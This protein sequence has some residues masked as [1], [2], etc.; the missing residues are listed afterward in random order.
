MRRRAAVSLCCALALP[1]RA[2]AQNDAT[3]EKRTPTSSEGQG[4]I[5]GCAGQPISD[6]VVITQP[7]FTERLPRRIEWVRTTVRR[8]HVNTDDEV[9]RR[10]LLLKVGEPCNQISRAESERILRAQP[11]LVEARIRV[12]D[13]ESGGVRL[14]VETRDDFSAIFS[15]VLSRASPVFRGLRFGESN[16]LGSASL[17]ALEWRDGEQLNDVLGAEFTDHQFAGERIELRAVAR[18]NFYGQEMRA[19]LVHPY[20][21]DLQRFAWVGSAG[22]TRDLVQL[23]RPDREIN[24]V[25][26]RREFANVG[27]IA[28]V[29]SVGR[30]K[31]LGVSLSRERERAD[32]MPVLI[33]PQGII[34]D[35]LSAPLSGFRR[36]RVVRVNA[37][38]GLRAVRFVRV[39][40]FDALTGEQDVRSGL[41]LG[42][43][44]GQSLPISQS[45]DRDRFLASNLYLGYGG[46]RSFAGFEAIA[47]ARQDRTTGIWD[48]VI[49][50]GRLAWYLR[51]A[52]KQ[53][54][55]LQ[56]EWATTSNVTVPFQLTLADRAGGILGH[57]ASRQPG[58]QRLVLRGEQR[59]VVPTR[60]NLADFG[61]SA[62]TEAGRLWGD[63]LVPFSVSTPWRGAVGVS[64][65]AAI[66]PRS[67]R[68][69]RVDFGVPFGNDPDRRFEVRFSSADRSRVFWVDPFDVRLARERTSPASLFT[70]PQ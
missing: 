53:T 17:A 49:S 61:L 10:F 69:W 20:Y 26:V 35:S 23:R 14:E 38:L 5:A 56:A 63:P 19:E 6:I 66:P 57:R 11:F 34:P 51:P 28:R 9:I 50:S 18:R 32:S 8:V 33:A 24:A 59:L 12:Y 39:Q 21:T 52:E 43:T 54:T 16:L 62:F 40:G 27:A 47:E 37:L 3:A 7:P 36:Q 68:L 65:L 1:V 31:L 55:L 41:Q 25:N 46:Q 64:I 60:F 42:I 29:G 2:H 45:S 44:A 13:D 30:L 48:N 58:S 67:R 15:P 70:W 4:S 22:G